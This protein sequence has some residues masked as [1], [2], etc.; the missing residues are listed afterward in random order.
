V[1]RPP[2]EAAEAQVQSQASA[3]LAAGSM[4]QYLLQRVRLLQVP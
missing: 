2:K 4:A 1:Q 3:E